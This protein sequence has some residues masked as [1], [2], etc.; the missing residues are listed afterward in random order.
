MCAALKVTSP[1]GDFMNKSVALIAVALL[2][3]GF[4]S[5]SMAVD[6]PSTAP[7]AAG[8]TGHSGKNH[9]H[10]GGKKHHHSHSAASATK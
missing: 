3:V 1:F 6:A 4:A 5:A 7:A 9:H 8:K 10:H 2:S